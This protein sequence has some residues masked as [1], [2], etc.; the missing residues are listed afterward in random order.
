MVLPMNARGVPRNGGTPMRSGPN[1]FNVALSQRINRNAIWRDGVQRES[2][3]ELKRLRE[4]R[5]DSPFRN[6]TSYTP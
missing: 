3:A 5:I 4:Q 6:N 1:N 2:T